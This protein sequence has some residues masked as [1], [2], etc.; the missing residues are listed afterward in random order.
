MDVADLFA[1]RPQSFPA[2]F[3]GALHQPTIRDESLYAGKAR[4]GLNLIEN[5]Q[6]QN[7]PDPGH[8]LHPG[9]RLH[10]IGFGTARELEFHCA[11]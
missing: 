5:D 8:R 3:F 10:I 11:Q 4:D 9:E 2:R 7:L 1:G 6:R